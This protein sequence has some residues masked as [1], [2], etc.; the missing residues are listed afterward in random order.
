MK[1]VTPNIVKLAAGLAPSQ[2]SEE[3]KSGFQKFIDKELVRIREHLE[4]IQYNINTQ[5]LVYTMVGYRIRKIEN[6]S[7]TWFEVYYLLNSYP[8]I[9]YH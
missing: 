1:H 6:V 2:L 5:D 8:R 4:S 7:L 9:F 3:I